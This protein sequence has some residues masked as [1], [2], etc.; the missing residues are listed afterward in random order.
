MAG[1]KVNF[2]FSLRITGRPIVMQLANNIKNL[3]ISGKNETE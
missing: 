2:T 1:Y 3:L